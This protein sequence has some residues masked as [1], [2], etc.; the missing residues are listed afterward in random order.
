MARFI[1]F[2]LIGYLCFVAWRFYMHSQPV[3]ALELRQQHISASQTLDLAVVWPDSA[4]FQGYTEA[5]QLVVDLA[6]QAG[7]VGC[8]GVA[9]LAQHCTKRQLRIKTYPESTQDREHAVQ[10]AKAI[11][12]N[13]NTLAVIGYQ[14]S[15][16]AVP[17]AI[18]YDRQ[19]ILM[20]S[21][22]ATH[23]KFTHYDFRRVFRHL[24]ADDV[25]AAL[26]ADYLYKEGFINLY[27][28]YERDMY[29]SDFSNFLM[30]YAVQRG[31]QVPTSH[32]FE[33]G[34]ID[35]LP[36]L[37]PL[38]TRIGPIN[39][40]QELAMLRAR[41]EQ[42]QRMNH[43]RVLSAQGTR[44]ELIRFLSEHGTNK[45]QN[46]QFF[47]ALS[48]EK[49]IEYLNQELTLSKKQSYLNTVFER[50]LDT[51]SLMNREQ[52][53]AE[54]EAFS[55][56]VEQLITELEQQLSESLTL[57][58]DLKAA[59]PPRLQT[60]QA[61]DFGQDLRLETLKQMR[62][63]IVR[64]QSGQVD[65]IFVAGFLP[66]LADVILQI[67]ELNI[68]SPIFGGN[69]LNDL[70]TQ[71]S[72]DK[73]CELY[74]DVYALAMHD[75]SEY[76]QRYQQ[77]HND[78]DSSEACTADNDGCIKKRY[79]CSRFDLAYQRLLEFDSQYQQRYGKQADHW[80][81]QGYLAAN[82]VIETLNAANTFELNVI[83]DT[84]TLQ[85]NKEIADKGLMFSCADVGVTEGDVMVDPMW[86]RKL[87]PH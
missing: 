30:E 5:A 10:Q 17:A 35:F 81:V 14:R 46:D 49:L 37:S 53:Y 56:L 9:A 2:G 55:V 79:E 39:L 13:L 22:G 43:I 11:A 66:E 29:G 6:N 24:A 34:Q 74:G 26:L 42:L 12:D 73:N 4:A 85:G 23:V 28:V 87:I 48:Y 38:R 54:L 64:I 69:T 33:P 16:A 40:T 86:V 84:L 15:D 20:L 63:K 68:K 44:Q 3:T 70:S 27:V 52:Q 1:L 36:I 62:K 71:C 50:H 18:V 72:Q 47:S 67:R 25:N 21:S 32:F 31:L 83:A 61:V 82:I 65:A 80:A 59:V 57:S 7:G 77:K 78:S 51:L 41:L 60:L 58:A 45:S 75:I 76:T 8:Q 19:G